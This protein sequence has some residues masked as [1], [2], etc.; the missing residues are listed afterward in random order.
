[1]VFD[2]I[3]F[4]L[5]LFIMKEKDRLFP[6]GNFIRLLFLV[7]FILMTQST[8][9]QFV[10]QGTVKSATDNQGLIGATVM[11]RGTRNGTTTDFEGKFQ[12][13]VNKGAVLEVSYIGFKTSYVDVIA[14]KKTYDIFL[15]EDSESLDEVVVIGYGVQKK[16][17]VTGA[18]IQVKSD[19]LVKMNAVSV[20]GA[21][22]SQ[23]PGVNI[24]QESG[25]PGQGFKVNIR[26]IGTVGDSSP[27]YVIDGVAGGDINS[28]NPTD[29]ES[30]D[31]LKDAASSAIYGSR[32]AN[33]VVLV[34]TKQGKA[35]KPTVTYDMY[36]GWQYM[37]KNLML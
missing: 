26:G 6:L 2:Y 15:S 8:W 13:T 14:N 19:D 27:L 24:V 21:L 12:L 20:L 18:T 5:L 3:N 9:A 22:Q 36:F 4:K 31:I 33:G 28:L 34:T 30:I 25:Q 32:A 10:I 17:L 16:K 37:P 29:I 7:S 1:M 35:G 11:E 23:S